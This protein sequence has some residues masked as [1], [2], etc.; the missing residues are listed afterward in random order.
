MGLKIDDLKFLVLPT[1]SIDEFESKI[2]SDALVVAFYVRDDNPAEDL[3][4][5]IESGMYGILDTEVSPGTDEE[6]NYVVFVEFQ[7]NEEVIDKLE[8][9]L[10][11]LKPLTGNKKW[12]FTYIDGHD[13][14]VDFSPNNVKKFV[15]LEEKEN[16]ND[17]FNNFFKES[18]L[19][20]LSIQDNVITIGRNGYIKSFEL[21]AFGSNPSFLL[22]AY[23]L[24]SKAFNLN[25]STLHECKKIR[26]LL[27]SNWD[28]NKVDDYFILAQ[29]ASNSIL[30]AK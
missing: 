3:S 23:D 17:E 11:S 20:H 2:D 12:H 18:M 14:S 13:Q 25:Q 29:S 24:D 22:E 30:I 21:I 27:G 10:N 9:I 15:R 6:G 5:F 1:I 8:T 26:N 28:I 4:Q 16:S 7:R 19:D